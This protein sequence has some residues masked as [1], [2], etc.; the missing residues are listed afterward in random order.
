LD[1][2][3]NERL[4]RGI[5]LSLEDQVNE[6]VQKNRETG[7][8]GEH[9]RQST[10]K[11]L[12]DCAIEI[13][14]IGREAAETLKRM[15]IRAA[16]ETERR[17]WPWQDI[18]TSIPRVV[19]HRKAWPLGPVI[20]AEDGLIYMSHSVVKEPDRISDMAVSY[21]SR[22]SRVFSALATRHGCSHCIGPLRDEARANPILFKPNDETEGIY[23]TGGMIRYS[24]ESLE[25]TIATEM[26][27]A[28]S[29]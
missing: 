29:R 16:L 1:E 21:K 28:L 5:N 26:A 8:E 19:A 14:E 27:N 11:S 23:L 4:K 24:R 6:A 25:R 20:V 2:G 22:V 18:V 17:Y 12:R 15:N 9:A 7:R 10:A 3:S 13:E